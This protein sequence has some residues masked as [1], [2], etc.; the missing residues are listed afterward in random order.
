M[1]PKANIEEQVQLAQ[2]IIDAPNEGERAD[3]ALTAHKLLEPDFAGRIGIPAYSLQNN[4]A[5]IK[6]IQGRIAELEARERVKEVLRAEGEE[7]TE[8][9]AREFK[10]G[11]LVENL[12][13][14]RIQLL[15]PGKPSDTIRTLLKANGFRWAP[16][17]GAWQRQLTNNARSAARNVIARIE[18]AAS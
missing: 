16:S 18:E 8:R 7:L 2:D 11:R 15:F 4:L 9:N 5:N 6:R 3:A 1:D 14:D 12:E 10:G 13:L 17:E